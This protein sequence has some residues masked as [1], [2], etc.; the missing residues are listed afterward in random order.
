MWMPETPSIS[1][2]SLMMSMQ[3]CRPSVFWSAAPSRRLMMASG[4][5]M[6]GTL[7]RIQR[8]VLAEASGPT[9]HRMKH[10]SVRPE[11]AHALHVLR[12]IGTSKQYWLCTNCAPAAIFLASRCGRKS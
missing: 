6:P 11:V 9:P 1:L 3:S 7:D 12:N 8:A 5:W 10:F 4:M 2:T